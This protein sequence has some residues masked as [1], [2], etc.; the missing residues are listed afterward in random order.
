V[1]LADEAR[2]A[3]RECGAVTVAVEQ[4]RPGDTGDTVI[5][6]A[7]VSLEARATTS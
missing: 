5:A 4:W 3:P 2:E 1:L 7:R 6:R